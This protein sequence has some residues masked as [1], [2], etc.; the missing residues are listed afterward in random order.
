MYVDQV[1]FQRSRTCVGAEL[2]WLHCKVVPV[3][4]DTTYYRG[5][6][7]GHTEDFTI[8][9]HLQQKVSTRQSV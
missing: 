3:V 2:T 9:L 8:N 1:H 6:K 5:D 4:P 7:S